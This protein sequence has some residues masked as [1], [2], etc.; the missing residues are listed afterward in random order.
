MS[1]AP[2]ESP[3]NPATEE[4]AAEH[5]GTLGLVPASAI[6]IA[7][8]LGTGMLFLPTL[9]IAAAGPA[10]LLAMTAVLILSVPL[11]GTFAALASRYPD[12]GGVASFVRRALGPTAAR[13]AGYWFFFGVIIGSPIVGLLAGDYLVALFGGERWLV[14]PVAA[15]M[16]IPPFIPNLFGF[17]VSS[18]VQLVLTGA[19]V[20]IVVLVLVLAAPAAEPRNFE[21][22]MPQGWAGV[23]A[24]ISLLVWAFAGWEAVTHVAAEF[25]NPRRT[26]PLATIIALVVV[27]VAY[28]ALQV[29]TVAVLG[30]NGASSTVPMLDMVSLTAPGVGPWIVTLVAVVVSLGVLNMY[31]GAFAKLGAA[32]ARDGDLPRW[33]APGAEAGGIP[34]RSLLLVAVLV[35]GYL[36]AIVLNGLDL[37]PFILINTSCMVAVY[38]LGMVAAVKL[39][40]TGS[41]GWWLALVSV[42]LVAGLLVLAGPHLLIPAVLG[43]AAVIVTV[44]ARRRSRQTTT[45]VSTEV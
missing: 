37:T 33:F 39:L 7:A 40:D 8:V 21:P 18:R 41:L 25:K 14:V 11:A 3:N 32:L 1:S 19:L 36:A 9:A 30:T 45:T 31:F 13:M 24:A 42:V 23:G 34:R 6:Y 4:V 5:G 10:S 29:V 44:V 27:G 17:T 16:M 12:S 15:L 26:I 43:L 28:L 35:Y 20:A 2:P 38:A 22:F